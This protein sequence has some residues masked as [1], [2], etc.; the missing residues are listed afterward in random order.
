MLHWVYNIES[1]EKLYFGKNVNSKTGA[2]EMIYQAK[3]NEF[4][5]YSHQ[6][7]SEYTDTEEQLFKS[8]LP[9][10]DKHYKIA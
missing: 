2:F 1:K 4:E 3:M 7:H 5:V 8:V 6:R 10:N 9:H